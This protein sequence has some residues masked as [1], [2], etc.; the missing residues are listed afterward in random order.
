MAI[1]SAPL[2][3]DGIDTQTALQRKGTIQPLSNVASKTEVSYVTH[4]SA[5][6]QALLALDT[7]QD[8]SNKIQNDRAF[9][10][11]RYLQNIAESVVNSLNTL[12]T[13]LTAAA[14]A[15]NRYAANSAKTLEVIDRAVTSSD[16]NLSALKRVGIERQ[17][18]GNF[19][20]NPAVVAK[21]YSENADDAFS[22]IIGFTS[23]VSRVPETPLS[24]SQKQ[25]NEVQQ[26]QEPE[27]DTDNKVTIDIALQQR[28]AAAFADAGAFTARKAVY[29]YQTVDS[30]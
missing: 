6:G 21:A 12:R 20:L 28:L 9:R 10:T 15:R 14:G 24:L 7:F 18:D 1:S 27:S 26:V 23:K 5:A 22:A 16:A 11:P 2:N 25:G 8:F 19:V 29:L 30:I 13:W 4:I 3:N 17:S